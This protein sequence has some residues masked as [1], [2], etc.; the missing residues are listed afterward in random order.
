MAAISLPKVAVKI[1]GAMVLAFMA[2]GF[3]LYVY[4]KRKAVVKAINPA[5]PENF[6]NRSVADVVGEENVANA[7]DYVFG[8]IDL[9]NPFNESDTYAKQVYGFGGE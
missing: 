1:D 7:A 8:A 3:A 6:V 5:D 2:A 4:S 9:I